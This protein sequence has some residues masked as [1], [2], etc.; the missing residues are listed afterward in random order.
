MLLLKHGANPE[1]TNASNQIPEQLTNDATL[2]NLLSPN[3]TTEQEKD[4]TP[5]IISCVSADGEKWSH[6]DIKVSEDTR[7]CN[8]FISDKYNSTSST[9]VAPEGN[10]VNGIANTSSFD[11]NRVVPE[12]SVTPPS[13][14]L[15]STP[16]S[17]CATNVQSLT[18]PD[19][20]ERCY[21]SSDIIDHHSGSCT[22]KSRQNSW[23]A[24][25]NP[26][27]SGN[28]GSC[29]VRS[30]C[31]RDSGSADISACVV[32]DGTTEVKQE[33]DAKSNSNPISLVNSSQQLQSPVPV[34]Q[35]LK[36]QS[37]SS[38]FSFSSDSALVLSDSQWSPTGVNNRS[39]SSNTGT[40]N[41]TGKS[42]GV[43]SNPAEESKDREWTCDKQSTSPP[44]PQR[45]ERSDHISSREGT[46]NCANY[47]ICASP[48]ISSEEEQQNEAIEVNTCATKDTGTRVASTSTSLQV[49]LNLANVPNL[50]HL[51]SA[52]S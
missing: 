32:A 24:N 20:R 28:S 4:L 25:D 5:N 49:N 13:N 27:S 11:H 2:R 43:G 35:D 22:D 39:S 17:N 19:H 40:S 45:S 29:D 41:I 50:A 23:P 48:P 44:G 46:T 1:I 51:V 33:Q 21:T 16:N 37:S 15:S 18:D 34:V 9:E 52:N 10:N 12:K 26:G 14:V 47:V 30:S 8:K 6:V 3:V 36:Y 42:A 31:S 7:Q 38:C